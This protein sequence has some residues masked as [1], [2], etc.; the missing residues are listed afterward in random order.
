MKL[1]LSSL[2][3]S[4]RKKLSFE[5]LVR[6]VADVVLVNLAILIALAARFLY[7]VAFEADTAIDFQSTPGFCRRYRF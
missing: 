2:L 7:V 3:T 6:L 4:F 5:G 1:D